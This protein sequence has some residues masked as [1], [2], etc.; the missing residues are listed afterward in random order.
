MTRSQVL[1]VGFFTTV[2]ALCVMFGFRRLGI[3]LAKRGLQWSERSLP[4][5]RAPM[6]GNLAL[7][8]EATGDSESA[9]YALQQEHQ[10][11][12]MVD[13]NFRIA[14]IYETCGDYDSAQRYCRRA[15]E[16]DTLTESQRRMIR[17]RLGETEST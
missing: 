15:L 12:P 14:M 4:K 1:Q 10:L 9:I 6:Y 8:Y 11:R 5:M 17:E 3:R 7:V 13:L 16:E 2:P